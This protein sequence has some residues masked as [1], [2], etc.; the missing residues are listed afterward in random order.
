MINQIVIVIIF[1]IGLFLLIIFNELVY[2]RLGLNGEVTRKFAHFTATLSAVSFPFLFTDHWYVLA[3]AII[4]FIVLFVSRRTRHLN[5]INA[6]ERDSFGS[7]LLPVSIYITFLVSHIYSDLQLY[8]LP[9]LI[10]AISDPAAGILGIN[11][12]RFNHRIRIFSWKLHKTWLG[13][14]TFFISSFFISILVLYYTRSHFDLVTFGIALTVAMVSTIIE[15][16]SIRGTDN[17]FIPISVV[18]VLILTG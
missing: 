9:M 10:L 4:F 16:F 18:A 15:M 7:F 17:L 3:L 11:I 8:I 14:I 12:K 5:S 2:R 6:I 1:I 13:S